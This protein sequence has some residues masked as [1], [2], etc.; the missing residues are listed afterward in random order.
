MR[1][2][3]A[4]YTRSITLDSIPTI[5]SRGQAQHVQR[6][7]GINK[8]NE[9]WDYLR[10]DNELWSADG[11]CVVHLCAPKTSRRGPSFKIPLKVV[12]QTD[13]P[14]LLEECLHRIGSA[15]PTISD[16]DN[17]DSG[18]S[19]SASGSQP[20]CSELYIPAPAYATRTEAHSFHLNTRNLF[21]YLLDVPLVGRSLGEALAQLWNRINQ[22]HPGASA[23]SDFRVYCKEQGY[24]SYVEN[25]QY[26]LA[27]LYFVEQTRTAD[28][29]TEAFV[30]CVGMGHDRLEDYED[31]TRLSEST[32]EVLAEGE[33]NMRSHI[34][35]V[36]KSLGT[37]LEEDLGTENLGLS[38]PLRDHLDRFRSI[39]HSFYV[40]EINGYFPPDE[41]DPWG[42]R[43]WHGMYGDFH[44][45]YLY[46]ADTKSSEDH[47]SN[48]GAQGGICVAQNLQAFDERHDF[49]AL[50]YTLPLIPDYRPRLQ[51]RA[52][53]LRRSLGSLR[54][55]RSGGTIT[56]KPT[57]G[58]AL[59]RATNSHDQSVIR[60]R[61]VQEYIRFEG[62]K[63]EEKVTSTEARKVRWLLVYSALQLLISITKAPAEVRDTRTPSY[64]L[65]VL[66]TAC[67]TWPEDQDT[68]HSSEEHAAQYFAAVEAVR[69][70]ADEDRISIHPDCE[71][72]CAAD[73]FSMNAVSRPGTSAGAECTTPS[74]L[75][76]RP[77]TLSR[78]ASIRS[79]VSTLHRSVVG[80][81]AR[82]NSQRRGSMVAPS[83]RSPTV[84]TFCETLHEL[85]GSEVEEVSPVDSVMGLDTPFEIIKSDD[86]DAPALE[87]HQLS[88]VD[89]TAKPVRRLR[90]TS[91]SIRHKRRK[92]KTAS[93][94]CGFPA[95]EATPMDL[96]Q[97]LASE[98][99]TLGGFDF[100]FDMPQSIAE[101][102][103]Q[104]GTAQSTEQL[105][106]PQQS[107][108]A[109]IA[110][111]SY[112]PAGTF[113]NKSRVQSTTSLV[114]M[115]SNAS[116]VY[117]ENSTQADEIEEEDIRGRRRLRGL[118][119]LRSFAL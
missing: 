35:Q 64:P 83:L 79:S 52:P 55:G 113:T 95:S 76:R 111:G 105:Q 17:S 109:G 81:L 51:E 21:A 107:K 65:C 66:D 29:W 82:R 59:S 25:P 42:K 119:R 56:T 78:T 31:Y 12:E 90:H 30:H 116:S 114:S 34:T 106:P 62:L 15:S 44:S 100:G 37:F 89:T 48:L 115:A 43:L 10:R 117:P 74:A 27:T 9:Q 39:L 46:L 28:M 41:S 26:S 67:P 69:K 53:E 49:A 85:Q 68:W 4:E 13:S 7:D 61:L 18:Y 36:T 72:S 118:D 102:E 19:G 104:H 60:N 45:L 5:N 32:R 91:G 71:A 94:D 24:L 47:A 22:W 58:Q 98:L 16:D 6:F 108:W 88:I 97:R 2:Q 33:A 63:M 8:R 23:E 96:P 92:S 3:R 20:G 99:G 93:V 11:N 103:P 112:V 54:I 73:Y 110:I 1:P 40:H 77:S 87:M 50:P 101:P 86:T 38:K 70:S 57:S 80:S 84:G 75:T 14:F